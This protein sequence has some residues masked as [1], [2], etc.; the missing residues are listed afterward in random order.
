MEAQKEVNRSETEIVRGNEKPNRKEIRSATKK[1][2]FQREREINC[3]RRNE[4]KKE[5]IEIKHRSS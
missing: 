3:Q 4:K 2:R 5:L 1:G